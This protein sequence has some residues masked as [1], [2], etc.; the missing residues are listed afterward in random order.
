MT[1]FWLAIAGWAGQTAVA[2]G[3]VF[4]LAALILWR[5]PAAGRRER[6]AAWAVRAAVL[7]AVVAAFPAWLRVPVPDWLRPAPAVAAAE[8]TPP[9]TPEPAADDPTLVSGVI[10]WDAGSAG[11]TVEPAIDPPQ[12]AEPPGEWPGVIGV[13][14]LAYAGLVAVGLGRMVVGAAALDRLRRNA[15]PAPYRVWAAAAKVPAVGPQV[16]VLVS[17][18]VRSPV[19]FGLFR[20]TV[21]LPRRLSDEA[22]PDE[23]RW[24]LAHEADHLR[25]GDPW[26]ALWAGLARCVYFPLPWFWPVRRQ[27]ELAQEHLADAAAVAAGGRPVDYAAFLVEMTAG[28]GDGRRKDKARPAGSV[29]MRAGNSDLYRR[30]T[31]LLQPKPGTTAR[32]SRAW[33][34]AAAGGVLTTGVLL[35]G[36]GAA[37]AD[38]PKEKKTEERRIAV[39]VEADEDAPKKADA[40]GGKGETKKPVKRVIVL[41][42]ADAAVDVARLQKAVAKLKAQAAELG[43]QPEAKAALEKTIAE[44]EKR[45][46]EAKAKGELK[47]APK[48]PAPPAPPAGVMPPVPPVVVGPNGERLLQFR[49]KLAEDLDGM[50][51][52]LGKDMERLAEQLQQKQ[53]A[54]TDPAVQEQIKRA[55]DHYKR[56][57]E[58]VK[59]LRENPLPE[60]PMLFRLADGQ[61]QGAPKVWAVPGQAISP[62]LGGGRMG[63]QLNQVPEAL[64]EQLDLPKDKGLIVTA[65]VE[66]SPAAKAGVKVNDILL[67]VAGKDVSIDPTE[68]VKQVAGLKPDTPFDVVVLRKGKKTTLTGMTLPGP[69]KPDA[70]KAAKKAKELADKD[71]AGEDVSFSTVNVSVNDGRFRIR[72]EGDGVRYTL[73]GA[74]EDGKPAVEQVE[75]REANKSV[76]SGGTEKLPAKYKPAVD[77]LLRN[78][79]GR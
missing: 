71:A 55:M 25:R 3:A 34:A 60:Q 76:Y 66:G 27:L 45:I 51:D 46:A 18:A 77:K 9:A 26:T 22:T 11:P 14:F 17:D 68:V 16:A 15:G 43:D 62:K 24:V 1:G 42:D 6:V 70:P 39:R 56:A 40:D 19:C 74:I 7:A 37:A 41:A 53:G 54:A 31:M 21:V 44:F 79:G 73:T 47:A 28:P 63:V 75:V 29:G 57:M 2:G 20:P 52:K 23:L 50:A 36:L 61:G 32:A 33:A 64:V 48:P 49:M 59:R 67:S 38:E 65:V 58:E 8:P 69:K 12:P 35:A 13:V 72:A 30:V 10:D 5:T 4:A 78:V